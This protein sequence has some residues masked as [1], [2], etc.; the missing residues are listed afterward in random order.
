METLLVEMMVQS[1]LPL[2]LASICENF[3]GISS[4]V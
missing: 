1:R 2:S 3:F 4:E